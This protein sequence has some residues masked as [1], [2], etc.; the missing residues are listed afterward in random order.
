[1]CRCFWEYMRIRRGL[2]RAIDIAQVTGG[3]ECMKKRIVSMIFGGVILTSAFSG[4]GAVDSAEEL[5]AQVQENTV[6]SVTVEEAVN[7]EVF[8][9][10]ASDEAAVRA[11][12]RE[13]F[14]CGMEQENPVLS[15]VSAY[16][17][18]AMA[19][20][21]AAGE[22]QKEFEEVLGEGFVPLS[23]MMMAA[24]LREGE[25]VRVSIANSAWVD[26]ALEPEEAWL[27][28]TARCF[29]AKVYRA[30][31]SSEQTMRD[32]NAW[33]EEN[34]EG[35]IL[36]FLNEPLKEDARL[37]LFDTVY[38]KGKWQSGFEARL[39]KP[40]EFTTADGVVETEFMAKWETD[41]RYIHSELGDGVILPYQDEQLVFVAVKPVEGLTVRQ[42]YDQ[43]DDEALEALLA[44]EET[45]LT[46]LLLPKFEI[47]FDRGLNEDLNAMGLQRAFDDSYADFSEIGTDVDGKP[48]YISLVRQKAVIIVDEEGTEASAVTEVMVAA[49]A[50]MQPPET[51]EVFFDEPFVYM[52][53]D[54]ETRVPLFLGILDRP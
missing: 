32:I 17:A 10:V 34:T 24:F 27:R 53:L 11:F 39:T 36:R 29:Q 51:V 1:M 19:G 30:E 31:L 49:G 48:L 26:D 33:V 5:T 37:A 47:T 6:A 42:M 2:W 44:S 21:G 18:L 4:C 13:L 16:L 45:V 20:S 8:C 41:Q 22:T 7:E 28:E 9:D 43:M 46:D 15:P 12:S 50:A 25:G 38:F 3:E 40:R 23:E 14:L 54:M 35:M 52:I